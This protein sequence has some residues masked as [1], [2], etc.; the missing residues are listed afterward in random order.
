AAKVDG[1]ETQSRDTDVEISKAQ[2]GFKISW[3]TMRTE[4]DDQSQSVV[5]ATSLTF[6]GTAKPTVFHGADSGDP[7]K[8]KKA[9]WAVITGKTLKISQFMLSDEGK[10]TMQVYERTLTTATDMDSKFTRFEDGKIAR[11]AELKLKKAP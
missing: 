1:A 10:W 6:R 7:T 9:V 8:G 2:D 11:Q 5:K 4:K 3:S